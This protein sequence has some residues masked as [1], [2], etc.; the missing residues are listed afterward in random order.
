MAPLRAVM[1]I[2]KHTELG[3]FCGD[4]MFKFEYNKVYGKT[5]EDKIRQSYRMTLRCPTNIWTGDECPISGRGGLIIV[6][7]LTAFPANPMVIAND[8]RADISK[9]G[10]TDQDRKY[11]N[12]NFRDV[13]VNG[14]PFL[15]VTNSKAIR[16]GEEITIYYGAEYVLKH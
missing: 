3:R 11:Q 7:E 9:S 4:E 2:P 10:M 14:W 12:S 15:M 16:K 8:P 1:D 6:D 13:R 5:C